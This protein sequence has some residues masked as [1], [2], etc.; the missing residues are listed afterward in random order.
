MPNFADIWE[1]TGEWCQESIWEINYSDFQAARNWG[2]GGTAGGTVVPTMLNPREYKTA[3]AD[4]IHVPGWSFCTVRQ[5]CY[6]SYDPADTRRDASIWQP[7]EGCYKPAYQNTGHFM[8]KY[9]GRLTYNA[10]QL[11][12]ADL[13]YNNNLRV[14]RFSEAL[15]YAA[16]LGSPNKQQYLDRVRQRAGVPS[17]P[18]TFDNIIQERAWEFLGEG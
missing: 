7:E 12:D 14:Y 5:S 17:V 11:A 8:A 9:A 2:W 4:G 13:N 10:S 15:L 3:V 16:E 1:V 6:D 18:A